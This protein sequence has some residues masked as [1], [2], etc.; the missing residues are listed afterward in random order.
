MDGGTVELYTHKIGWRTRSMT[1]YKL[2]KT[3]IAPLKMPIGVPTS[4]VALA[5]NRVNKLQE[6]SDLPVETSR[7]LLFW[8]YLET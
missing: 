1:S 8:E 3:E 5:S 2:A 7:A 6:G 4:V